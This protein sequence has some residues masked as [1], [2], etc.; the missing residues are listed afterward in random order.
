M[1]KSELLTLGKERYEALECPVPTPPEDCGELGD[2]VRCR[3][4]K[5]SFWITWQGHMTACGM[6]SPK[7]SPNVFEIPFAQGWEQVKASTAAIRLP[8]KCA[9]CN[10]KDICHACA[11]M[12]FTESGS[13]DKAPQ[14]RCDMMK[15]YPGCWQQVK[16]EHL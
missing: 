1:A 7:N 9:G 10:A 14:Y 12:V 15:A 4:G 5:C 6:L 2:G 13:F 16:T 11:A 8:A 3:A